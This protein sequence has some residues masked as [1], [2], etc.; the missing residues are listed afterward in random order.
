M[1]AMR[2]FTIALASLLWAVQL[3]FGVGWGLSA[4]HIKID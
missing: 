4:E 3:M 2:V 1:V